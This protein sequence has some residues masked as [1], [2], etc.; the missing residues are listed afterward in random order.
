MYSNNNDNNNREKND[1]LVTIGE[2]DYKIKYCKY[3]SNYNIL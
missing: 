1:T 3:S 2:V